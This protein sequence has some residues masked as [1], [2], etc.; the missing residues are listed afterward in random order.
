MKQVV[1]W[2]SKGLWGFT[3]D[4]IMFYD[5]FLEQGGHDLF[6]GAVEALQELAKKAEVV[7]CSNFSSEKIAATWENDVLV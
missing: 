7:F 3:H 1:V 4:S 2:D 5:E 6:P